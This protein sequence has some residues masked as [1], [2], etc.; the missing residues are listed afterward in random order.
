MG[1]NRLFIPQ[2]TL[3]LW[4][5]EQ[6]ADIEENELTLADDG[7]VYHL[8]T[9]V[10]FL[11]EATGEDD[12]ND[13][14]GRVKEEAQLTILGAEAYLDSVILEDNAYDVTRGF[15]AVPT[16]DPSIKPSKRISQMPL[17]PT[18]PPPALDAFDAAPEGDDL[19]LD[20]LVI[21]DNPPSTLR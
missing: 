4:V 16:V 20:D 7:K 2:E 6:R 17:T 19:L 10:L 3:D 15:V 21:N 11:R 9:A 5:D 18:Q 14:V 1:K 12:P 8:A 13:L